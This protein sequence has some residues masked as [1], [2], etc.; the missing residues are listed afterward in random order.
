MS[1][2]IITGSAGLIGSEASRH[3]AGLGLDVLGIDNDMRS[4]F[5]GP[6]AS[7]RRQRDRLHRE[8]SPW[9]RHLDAD[10]DQGLLAKGPGPPQ[11]RVIYVYRPLDAIDASGQWMVFL[12]IG[13]VAEMTTARVRVCDAPG[14]RLAMVPISPRTLSLTVML[15]RATSPVLVTR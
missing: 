10:I 12:V 11:R 2:A 4:Q 9:Y 5:F 1:V 13:D 14:A 7:T 8:L 15:V 6:E 3:F